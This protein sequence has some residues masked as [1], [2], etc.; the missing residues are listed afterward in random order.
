MAVSAFSPAGD[1]PA[2]DPRPVSRGSKIQLAFLGMDSLYLVLEYP[3]SDVFQYWAGFVDDFSSPRL[4]AGVPAED[5][6][7]RRAG[8]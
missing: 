3:H 6:V 8:R 1:L 5:V 4:V 7:L 2:A